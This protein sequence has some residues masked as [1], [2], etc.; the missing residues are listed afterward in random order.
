MQAQRLPSLKRKE[1]SQFCSEGFQTPS[2][3][4]ANL[5]WRLNQFH[6]RA[7]TISLVHSYDFEQYMIIHL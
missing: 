7:L 6:F 1:P 4:A 3:R 2:N 5:R